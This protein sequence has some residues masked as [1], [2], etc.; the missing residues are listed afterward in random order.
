MSVAG[1]IAQDFL[2]SAEWA[3][4]VD[5]PFAVAQRRQIGAEGFRV[6]QLGLLAEELQ[7][8]S[9]MSDDELLKEQPT[10]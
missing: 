10:E 7:V 5:V 4:A 3:L 8:A 9:R 6:G 1:E 2:R